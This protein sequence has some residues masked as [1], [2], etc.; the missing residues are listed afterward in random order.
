M[1]QGDGLENHGMGKTQPRRFESYLRRRGRGRVVESAGLK[2]RWLV[3]QP[4]RG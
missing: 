3:R 4:E 1:I 2:N